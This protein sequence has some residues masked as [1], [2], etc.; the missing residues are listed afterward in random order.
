LQWPASSVSG[1]EEYGAIIIPPFFLNVLSGITRRTTAPWV[2]VWLRLK[3][4]P[5]L[6]RTEPSLSR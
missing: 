3:K 4:G 2:S 6:C 1:A 5:A